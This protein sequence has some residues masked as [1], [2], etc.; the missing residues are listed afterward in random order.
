MPYD[1]IL[2]VEDDENDVFIL[3]RSLERARIANPLVVVRD[4]LEAINYLK[5]VGSPATDAPKMPLLVLLD[6]KM[7]IMGGFEVLQWIRQQPQLNRVVV[8]VFSSSRHPEDIARAYDL[9][10][11]S[12]LVKR[13]S[14][15]ETTDLLRSLHN[16]WFCWNEKP[17]LQVVLSRLQDQ[18]G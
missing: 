18:G 15:E 12:F 10:A 13:S 8:I 16:Y 2:L 11:N 9:H 4:G 5:G 3:K 17:N 1:P 7:P 6:I 14:M